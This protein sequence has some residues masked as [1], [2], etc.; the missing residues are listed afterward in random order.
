MQEYRDTCSKCGG[1][2]IGDGY[3]TVSHCENADED[4]YWNHEPD[5]N[6]VEC[7]FEYPKE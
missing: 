6:P 7:D 3:T 1:D 5:A 2:M 4:K